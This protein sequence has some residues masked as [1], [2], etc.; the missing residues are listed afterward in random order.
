MSCGNCG[1]E[2]PDDARF[3]P[4]CGAS[5]REAAPL[6]PPRVIVPGSRAG[7]PVW[8]DCEIGWW[9]GYIKAE[10]YALALHP[11]FGEYEVGRSRSF[12]WRRS[13][14]PPTKKGAAAKAH[15]ALVSR[16]LAEGWETVDFGGPWYA[17]AFRRR[18]KALVALPPEDL[19][20]SDEG[21]VAGSP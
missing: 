10:F 9:R 7:G 12:W 8:E 17:R 1:A 16:L 14:P 2:Y 20:R 4:Q 3:C 13:E 6:D 5:T 18:T 11:V 21:P 15:D 19:S